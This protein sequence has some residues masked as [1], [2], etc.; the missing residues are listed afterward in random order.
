MQVLAAAGF[1]VIGQGFPT[2]WREAIGAANPDGFFESELVGGI[3]WRTNPH[4]VTGRFLF[5]EQTVRHAVKVF[6]PGLVR[7][8]LAFLDHVIA[9]VRHPAEYVASMRRLR[10]IARPEGVD[11]ELELDPA[12]EWW[13][14]NFSLVRDLATRR[15]PVHVV[16][17]DRLVR[18]PQETIAAVLR[19]LGDGDLARAVAAVEPGH[20]TQIVDE[21]PADLGDV[22]DAV[23]QRTLVELWAR[24]DRNEPL[25]GPFVEEMNALDRRLRPKLVE[26]EARRKS[27]LVRRLLDVDDEPPPSG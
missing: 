13:C 16:S 11:G 27:R 7:S 17:Y 6:V 25:S 1:P 19:W 15:Y 24:I 9:T 4:P 8:D 20:R 2:G 26:L 18:D 21:R 12:V 10:S 3:Y 5:P 22:L 14:D 23:E